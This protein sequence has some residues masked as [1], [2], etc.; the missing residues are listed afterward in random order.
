[1][2]RMNTK[3]HCSA[4]E[5]TLPGK[6][7]YMNDCNCTLCQA[8]GGVWDYYAGAD[9]QVRGETRTYTRADMADPAIDNHFCGVC[10]SNTH[11]TL[12]D[13]FQAQ[14]PDVDR[15]GVNM[16]LVAD[17]RELAGVELRFPDGRNWD[18]SSAALPRRAPRVVEED[19]EF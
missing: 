1:M 13:A 7:A 3:C 6:P 2:N 8:I 12:T 15:V 5:I 14:H 19:G 10:S 11:W 17:P 9:V 4:V 16:R 18:G